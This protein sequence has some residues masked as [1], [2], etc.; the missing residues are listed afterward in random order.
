MC[1]TPKGDRS[2]PDEPWPTDRPSWRTTSSPSRKASVS[3]GRRNQHERRDVNGRRRVVYTLSLEWPRPAQS[4][5]DGPDAPLAR[6]PPP[7]PTTGPHPPP[8]HP[9]PP[10]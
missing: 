3:D 6:A 2:L 4:D 8:L 5:R 1:S 9:A 10:P 7:P